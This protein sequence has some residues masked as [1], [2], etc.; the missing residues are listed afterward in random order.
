[1]KRTI[2]S[3]SVHSHQSSIHRKTSIHL[4]GPRCQ[5]SDEILDD[6]AARARGSI[7]LSQSVCRN[8]RVISEPAQDVRLRLV[9]SW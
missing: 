7:T 5:A 2:G 6:K 8:L 9:V 1:M 4:P 3:L